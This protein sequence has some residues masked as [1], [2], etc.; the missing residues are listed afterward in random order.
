MYLDTCKNMI[1]ILVFVYEFMS[2]NLGFY[3]NTIDDMQYEMDCLYHYNVF[4]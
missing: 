1:I 3:M 4:E 2:V